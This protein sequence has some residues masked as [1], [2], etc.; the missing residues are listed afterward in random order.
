VPFSSRRCVPACLAAWVLIVLGAR[1]M[2]SA[3]LDRHI[4]KLRL[5]VRQ[6]AALIAIGLAATTFFIALTL[7]AFT[8]AGADL[9][10]FCL[11]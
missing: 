2:D 3:E 10:Y 7:G 6:Y 5:Y 9:G 4:A 8:A 1:K 11:S